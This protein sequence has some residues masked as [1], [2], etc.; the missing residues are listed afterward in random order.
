AW[1]RWSTDPASRARG[2][3]ARLMVNRVWQHLYGQGI[4]ATP[5]NFG[6]GGEP[7]THPELLE[8]L[9]FEFTHSGGWR[10]KPLI[11]LL[12]TSTAYRQSSRS[13]P[14]GAAAL[15]ADPQKV[16]PGNQLLWRPRLRGRGAQASP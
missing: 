11:K 13:E 3:L 8:W 2:L 6:L 4:V 14:V 12:M 10:I 7:P 1:A 16:D 5:E 9:S 15:A